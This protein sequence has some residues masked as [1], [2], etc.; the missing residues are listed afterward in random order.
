MIEKNYK[1]Y[2]SLNKI[3]DFFNKKIYIEE[4][5]GVLLNT[6]FNYSGIEFRFKIF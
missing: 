6:L 2:Q 1:I 5:D 4:D 3:I